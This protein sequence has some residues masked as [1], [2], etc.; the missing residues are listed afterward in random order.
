[1]ALDRIYVLLVPLTPR[2][3]AKGSART[4]PHNSDAHTKLSDLKAI[5]PSVTVSVSSA[6]NAVPISSR[7]FNSLNRLTVLAWASTR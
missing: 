5:W 3:T 2:D 1:M 7:M 6:R 4:T